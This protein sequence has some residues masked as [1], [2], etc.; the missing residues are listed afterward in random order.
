MQI[1]ISRLKTFKACRRAYYF[2]YMENLE[3]IQ[4]AEALETGLAY[5]GYV[6]AINR[7]EGLVGDDYSKEA[8]MARAYLKFIAPKVAVRSVEAWVS[9]DLGQGDMLIGRVDGLTEDGCI[10]EHK[11][12]SAEITEE[13]EY[14]LQ[15][16]EQILAY[17]LCT[18]MRKIYY[19]VCRKPT[20]KQKKGET[21]EEF[22]NRM[23]EWYDE[24]TESKI[25]LLKIE[26]T[27][28]EVEQFRKELIGTMEE[29]HNSK[30]M[31]RNCLHCFKWG[32]QCEYAPI[33]LTYEPEQEYAE[34][35]KVERSTYGI[36]ENK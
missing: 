5:H 14:N 36:P 32:R 22:Y 8:A 6:E 34:F 20:I 19:T 35:M 28:E 7:S 4:K 27:D 2:K 17:M 10:I 1:S 30:V 26:R 12:T 24:D 15:W 13:Y 16:D 23:V 11:T 29:V 18:G 31:Y 33:C 9:C 3:P 21:D 25:R